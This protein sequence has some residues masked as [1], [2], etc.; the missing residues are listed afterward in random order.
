[1]RVRGTAGAVPVA[2][3]L[4]AL[5]SCR[6]GAAP[7]ELEVYFVDRP[8]PAAQQQ[9]RQSCGTL[10]GVRGEAPRSDDANVFFDI[11][12]ASRSQV[13]ALAGCINRLSAADPALRIR[14]Y[15]ILDGSQG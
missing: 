9:V 3:L 14:S 6:A 13:N 8:T 10:P 11:H 15:Q 1:M 5:A 7:G 4:L 12:G 2:G